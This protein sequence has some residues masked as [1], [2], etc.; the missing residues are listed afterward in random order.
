MPIP[1]DLDIGQL[2]RGRYACDLAELKSLFVGA[3]WAASSPTRADIWSD[4]ETTIDL[5]RDVD[6]GLPTAVWIGG[7][8]ITSR[9][10]PDDIDLTFLLDGDVYESLS[11]TKKR[12]VDRLSARDGQNCRLR[13]RSNLRVDCFAIV[14]R[15]VALP[16]KDLTDEAATYFRTRGLWDDWWQRFRTVAKGSVPTIEGAKP[17]RGYLEVLL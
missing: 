17:V 11:N 14:C 8:F 6:P 7:S 5:F 10:D 12:K 1:F 4:F 16:W 2:P 9:L 3:N 13:T 15:L